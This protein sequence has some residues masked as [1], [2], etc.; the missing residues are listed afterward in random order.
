MAEKRGN[1]FLALKV[2]KIAA[3][4]GIDI[5]AL[6]HPVGAIPDSA[7]ISGCRQGARLCDRPPGERVQRR[8]GFGRRRARPA[9]A[10]ARHRQGGRQE[11]RP[12]LFPGAADHRRRLQRDARRRLSR[13]AARPLRRLLCADL[14]RLQCRA[15]PRA[16]VDPRYGDPRGKDIEAVVDWIERIPFTETRSYVQR[17]MENYQ[18]YKMRLSGQIRH[19]GRSRQR[20]VS[21]FGS[22]SPL[23]GGIPRARRRRHTRFRVWLLLSPSTGSGLGRRAAVRSPI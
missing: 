5:G 4:R 9:A 7:D 8:R 16:G 12:G 10:S 21:N 19:R 2:G 15:R 17:V 14:R 11:G 6:S 18:V 22:G 13:R 20:A 23:R 3:A 1:H